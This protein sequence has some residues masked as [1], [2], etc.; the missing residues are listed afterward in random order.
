MK[1]KKGGKG[2]SCASF[3]KPKHEMKTEKY[4]RT[5]VAHRASRRQKAWLGF[6]CD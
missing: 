6:G 2:I 3:N 5:F 4:V 1:K